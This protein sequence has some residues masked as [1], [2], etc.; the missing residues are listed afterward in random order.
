MPCGRDHIC[1]ATR[2]GGFCGRTNNDGL[3]ADRGKAVDLST[4]L[5][6]D[7]VIFGKDL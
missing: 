7:N 3:R 1:A 6:F 5:N 2:D 4:K